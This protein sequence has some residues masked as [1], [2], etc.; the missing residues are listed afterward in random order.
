MLVWT[1]PVWAMP[2]WAMLFILPSGC[3]K[4]QKSQPV[5]PSVEPTASVVLQG[6]HK[7]LAAIKSY[8]AKLHSVMAM[9]KMLHKME[10]RSP[11]KDP[12]EFEMKFDVSLA[13]ALPDRMKMEVELKKKSR[14]MRTQVIFDKKKAWTFTR[15]LPDKK[16]TLGASPEQVTVVD[17]ERLGK[18]SSPFNIGFNFRG[19]GLSEG[20][21]LVGTIEEFLARYRFAAK[22]QRRKLA[23]DSYFVLRGKLDVDK[24]LSDHFADEMVMGG[25][26]QASNAKFVKKGMVGLLANLIR[27]TSHIE[28]WI[29]SHDALP[30]RYILGDGK[31][32]LMTVDIRAF[33][34][35]PPLS[36]RDFSVSQE[37]GKS[38]QDTT[39]T[40]LQARKQMAENLKDAKAVKKL[41]EQLKKEIKAKLST[42]APPARNDPQADRADGKSR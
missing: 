30:R 6:L 4:V 32:P 14:L 39:D 31:D 29:S 10:K 2:V 16:S 1:M 41:R 40:I 9:G 17:L 5:A 42:P 25:L 3:P 33:E 23:S 24:L 7:R 27:H 38:A 35:N 8:R 15:M 37:R 13:V 12:R 19:H 28:L 21:D 26:V 20:K 11:P 36:D 18:R 34:A 22:V